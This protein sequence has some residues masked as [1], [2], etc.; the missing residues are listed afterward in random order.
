MKEW[1][2]VGYHAKSVPL[3]AGPEDGDVGGLDCTG[4]LR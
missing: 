3:P 1:F 4:C 2:K